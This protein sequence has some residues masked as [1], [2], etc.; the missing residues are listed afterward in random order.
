MCIMLR[1]NEADV[2]D[3][4]AGHTRE[5]DT[6]PHPAYSLPCK[7]DPNTLNRLESN[8]K[9]VLETLSLLSNIFTRYVLSCRRRHLAVALFSPSSGDAHFLDFL[10]LTEH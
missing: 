2:R 7:I 5:L 10:S 8:C 1:L 4:R 6:R 9:Y 3:K